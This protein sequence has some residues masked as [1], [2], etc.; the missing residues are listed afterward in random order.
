VTQYVVASE[1]LA[2]RIRRLRSSRH[3]SRIELA[4]TAGVSRS[5]VHQIE[6]GE[7]TRMR[8]TTLS[9]HA[10]ALGVSESYI[11]YG[12]GNERTDS[13]ECQIDLREMLRQ[14]TRL[15]DSQI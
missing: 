8:L 11:H 2:D 9:K 13:R 7:R 10:D 6:T 12:Y 5:H 1:T 14:A 4:H 3:M 15:K